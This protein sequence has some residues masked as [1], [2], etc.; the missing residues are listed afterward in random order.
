MYQKASTIP[1]PISFGD[2]AAAPPRPQ[3][4]GNIQPPNNDNPELEDL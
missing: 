3:Q 1:N 4:E 2:I